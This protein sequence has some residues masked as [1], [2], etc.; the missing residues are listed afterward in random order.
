MD[1]ISGARQQKT[2]IGSPPAQDLIFGNN[3]LIRGK[4]VGIGYKDD[5]EQRKGFKSTVVDIAPLKQRPNLYNV[6]LIYTKSNA[7]NGEEW[8]PEVGD[9]VAVTF[10]DGNLRD[11]VVV[12]FLA[13]PNNTIQAAEAEAPCSHRKM[14][15]TWEKIEK[16]GTRRVY[17]KKD[18]VLE[19]EGDG[20]I[21][22]KTGNL[23]IN[24]L[25]GN[26]TISTKGKTIVKSEGTVEIDGVGS[27]Q[28]KGVVQGDC[29]CVVTGKPHPHISAS[30]KASK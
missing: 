26:T 3:N 12:G 16:D 21:T 7:D 17:V 6:P 4:I 5:P 20:T 24:V 30:V 14:N 28:V 19:I 18:E 13:R 1:H 15:G 10:F 2:L 27:G 25:A 11:P 22:V 8:T 29:L 23:S 9:I